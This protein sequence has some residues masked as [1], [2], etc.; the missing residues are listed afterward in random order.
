VIGFD[1]KT[2]V[3]Q[4]SDGTIQGTLVD[5]DTMELTYHHTGSSVVVAA[6]RVKRQR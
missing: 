3:A 1:G 5:R 2:I 6:I 4:D